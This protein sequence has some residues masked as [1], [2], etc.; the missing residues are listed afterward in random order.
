MMTDLEEPLSLHFVQLSTSMISD[1]F[2]PN[3]GGVES[4]LYHLSQRL[5]QRGHKVN[6]E[7]VRDKG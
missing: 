6:T 7:H 2:Y 5:I 4:H 3:A 1:F